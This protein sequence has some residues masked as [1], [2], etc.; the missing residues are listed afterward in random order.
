[1][2]LQG[3]QLKSCKDDENI[4]QGK[5]GT[6]AALGESHNL[7]PSLF[8]I[9]FG[10]I[11]RGKPDWKKRGQLGWRLPTSDL[12]RNEVATLMGIEPM[13]PP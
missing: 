3:K 13:L 5:R 2:R 8:P 11:V 1:M 9:W 4:A 10:A 12:A 7:I 6:S